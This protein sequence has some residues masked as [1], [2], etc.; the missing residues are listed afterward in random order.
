M[1]T[2]DKNKMLFSK[3]FDALFNHFLFGNGKPDDIPMP[4]I[5][6]ILSKTYTMS[7]RITLNCVITHKTTR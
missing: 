3:D 4:L 6:P 7:S 2:I 1:V 5:Q